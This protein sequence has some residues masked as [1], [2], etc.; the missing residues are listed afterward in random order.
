MRWLDRQKKNL[1]SGWLFQNEITSLKSVRNVLICQVGAFGNNSLSAQMTWQAKKK[2][3]KQ[4][5]FLKWLSFFQECLNL[6]K[7]NA[8]ADNEKL[9]PRATKF[10]D[11]D[12]NY[13]WGTIARLQ[14]K[15]DDLCLVVTLPK[16][17]QMNCY[18][19]VEIDTPPHSF[20]ES[21]N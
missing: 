18:Q 13:K 8:L 14:E 9:D 1:T 17:Y 15:T 20:K 16:L 4:M 2:L 3:D 19:S 11:G 21:N 10:G 7:F 6:R 12:R 5:T